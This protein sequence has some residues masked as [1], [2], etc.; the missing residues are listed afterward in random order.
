MSKSITINYKVVSGKEYNNLAEWKADYNGGPT[1]PAEFALG[2][3][4]NCSYN[5]E[6]QTMIR[7]LSFA[8][9]EDFAKWEA[10][11]PSPGWGAEDATLVK[12]RV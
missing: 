5:N 1:I 2:V 7:V 11:A 10:N 4:Q 8:T 12:T 9:D 3:S 6:S